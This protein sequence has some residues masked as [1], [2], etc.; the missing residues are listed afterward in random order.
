[1]LTQNFFLSWSFCSETNVLLKPTI[2]FFFLPTS[3]ELY[4]S[5]SFK[6][7]CAMV[8]NAMLVAE[9]AQCTCECAQRQILC[10]T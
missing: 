1:M 4:V 10:V 7:V 8:Q 9:Y 6:Y 2:Q 3:T 5:S